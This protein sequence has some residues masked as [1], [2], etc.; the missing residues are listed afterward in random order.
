MFRLGLFIAIATAGAALTDCKSGSGGGAGGG[1]SVIAADGSSTVYPITEAMAEEFEKQSG[2]KVTIGIAGTGGG[3]KRF[4][5]G[6]IAIANASR[7]IKPSE[8]AQCATAKV[9]FVE[10]PVAYDGIAIVVHPAN[11]WC[12]TMT[13]AELKTLWTPE[14]QGRVLKWNDVRPGWPDREIH[15]FGPGVDSGTYDY[16]TQAVVGKEGASRGDYTSSE[17]DNV[18]VQGVANDPLALG[19]F[20]LAYYEENK[21]K[22]KVVGIDDGVAENGAGPIVPSAQTVQNGTYQPLSRPLFLYVAEKAATRKE[23]QDFMAFYL[24]PAGRPLV[25]EVGYVALP[26]SAQALVTARFEAR[27]LGTLFASGTG[28]QVGLTIEALLARER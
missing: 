24:G 15:L 10:L 22:L 21:A 17:D 9:G 8:A 3:F 19:F 18:V 20:G 23:V 13:V 6:E 28:S 2:T 14:A 4:C 12:T 11:D 16:F 26:E 25:T 1:A 7:P 5:A 27:K